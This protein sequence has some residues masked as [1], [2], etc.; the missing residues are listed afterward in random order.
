MA[1]TVDATGTK[2]I[3][4]SSVASINYTGITVGSGSNMVLIVTLVL[5]ASASTS[6]WAATWDSGGTN[7]AMTLL[8]SQ[9]TSTS[10]VATAVIFGLRN[11]TSGNKTLH[12]TWTGSQFPV[13][14]AISFTGVD[15]TSD[16]AAFPNAV[17]GTTSSLAVTSATGDIPVGLIGAAGSLTSLN[18]TSIYLDKTTSGADSAASRA[19]GAST[20][21]FT[22]TGA[23]G[24]IAMVG[25]DIAQSVA[26]VVTGWIASFGEYLF[27]R[28]RNV[29]GY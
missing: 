8:K 10:G 2:L 4:G 25:V 3:G 5:G 26:S 6:A 21:T 28:V 18:Q 23:T 27:G 16:A 20:V 11:P 22:A 17:A 15:T 9:V 7:Q 14:C 19:A 12:L 24:S 1:V 29:V 13:V